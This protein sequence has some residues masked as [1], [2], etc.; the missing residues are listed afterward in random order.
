MR[1]LK[2]LDIF[3]GIGGFSHALDKIE[4]NGKKVFETVAFCE[5][6]KDAQKVLRKHW[7]DVPIF[8]DI[9]KVH[10]V[11][12]YAGEDY[13]QEHDEVT[14]EVKT[15]VFSSDIDIIVGGFPC[16]DISTAGLQKGLIDENGER[17]RSGLWSEYKRLIEALQPKWIV[18]ENV[19]NLLSNGLATVLKDLSEIGFD[20]E[21]EII[22]ARSVG[23]CH[24][25]ERIWIVAYPHGQS[26]R[27][28]SK[29]SEIRRDY[30]QSSGEAESGPHGKDGDSEITY[31]NDFRF[32]PSFASEEE[33][34][35][36]WSRA[37]IE[38]RNWWEAQPAICGNND[39]LPSRLYEGD[40]RDTAAQKR[41][42]EKAR[43]ARIK[44]L[45]NSIVPGIVQIIGERIKYHEYNEESVL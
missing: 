25:R 20:A 15:E 2:C 44:Q 40:D 32:R 34:S 10:P 33:K 26:I 14:G 43:Q 36:W 4:H 3:S 6:D 27:E 16:T 22:S 23:A 45:G 12:V 9:T 18:I 17:T 11:H 31:P 42:E 37:T 41:A 5:W 29:W 13:L 24:L 21:W 35:E 1:T 19:R 7:P 8:G 38:L 28:F 30:L 39:E